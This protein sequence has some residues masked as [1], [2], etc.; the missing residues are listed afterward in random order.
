MM[1]YIK[2]YF[3]KI[4]INMRVQVITIV[5]KMLNILYEKEFNNY[6]NNNNKLYIFKNYFY[7][8]PD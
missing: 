5:V 7:E 3:Q 6:Y 1:V 2:T 4:L 8:T